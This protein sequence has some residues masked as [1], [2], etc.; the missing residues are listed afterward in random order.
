MSRCAIEEVQVEGVFVYQE[1]STQ[2]HD[3]ERLRS[4]YPQL[5]T[6]S[7]W[8]EKGGGLDLS[9]HHIGPA[10]PSDARGQFD[11]RADAL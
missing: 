7:S 9:R 8:L 1:A 4:A 6:F 5:H 2:V 3:V 11:E 10:A